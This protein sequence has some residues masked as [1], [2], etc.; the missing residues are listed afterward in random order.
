MN[1]EPF[2]PQEKKL[3]ARYLHEA[4]E[5]WNSLL[6]YGAYILPTVLFAGYG[7]WNRDFVAT[8]IAYGALLFFVILS[9]QYHRRYEVLWL[10]ILRKYEAKTGALKDIE[11]G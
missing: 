1:P 9:L 6:S 2:T 7:L 8:L 4:S 10:S 11:P 5:P 3:I